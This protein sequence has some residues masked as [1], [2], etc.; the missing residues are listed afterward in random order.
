MTLVT[1]TKFPP[2]LVKMRPMR[3]D[4]ILKKTQL[5][6]HLSE[7][8]L[9]A[10]SSRAVVRRF[11]V[12]EIIFHEGQPCEGL[13]VIAQ[14]TLRLFKTSASGREQI[15]AEEGPGSSVAELPVFDG[16]AYPASAMAATDCETVFLSRRDFRSVCLEHPEVTLKVLTIVGARLRRLVGI[17]E[18]L[19]FTTVRQ[20]LIAFLLREA[21]EQG[22]KDWAG[23][24]FDL[25]G[26]HQELANRLGTV[27]E[28][29]SRNLSRLQAEKLIVTDGRRIIVPDLA[30]LKAEQE[31]GSQ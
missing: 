6:T 23:V 15:L 11:Q 17:I 2:Q 12:G 9:K 30:K 27:R 26:T 7:A 28:L 3:P 31:A 4:E 10:L 24:G 25:P 5:F 8:E 19:S 21:D 13:H 14:G 22:T 20:R 1:G 18:E 29:V 16:G